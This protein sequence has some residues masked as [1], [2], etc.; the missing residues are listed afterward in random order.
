MT[1]PEHRDHSTDGQKVRAQK[2][3]SPH[4][5]RH[6]FAV[7]YLN[8]GGSL[9]Q[10]QVLLGHEYISTTLHYLK[11]AKPDEGKRVSVLDVALNREGKKKQSQAQ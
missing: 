7:H 5:L 10:L 6:T 4:T 1:C 11:Y 8:A 3:I 2:P 9:R